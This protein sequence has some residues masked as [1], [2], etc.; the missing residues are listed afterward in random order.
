MIGRG[1]TMVTGNY[2]GHVT[3]TVLSLSKSRHTVPGATLLWSRHCYGHGTVTVTTSL[4][5]SQHCYDQVTAPK[6][7]AGT[8]IVL[9]SFKIL[10]HVVKADDIDHFC[11]ILLLQGMQW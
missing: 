8:V 11:I 4:S 7:G 9:Y 2:F 5:R 3:V 10:K 1:I 6:R